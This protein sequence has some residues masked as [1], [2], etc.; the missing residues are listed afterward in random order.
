M[1]SSLPGVDFFFTFFIWFPFRYY[2]FSVFQVRKIKIGF[3]KTKINWP[4]FEREDIEYLRI[5][6]VN[7]PVKYVDCCAN[8]TDF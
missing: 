5:K 8:Y 4:G 7:I 3:I 1:I 2:Y 6:K